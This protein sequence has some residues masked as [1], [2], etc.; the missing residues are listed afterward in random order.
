MQE[1]TQTAAR[2]ACI[3]FL[4]RDKIQVSP[5]LSVFLFLC[6]PGANQI[7]QIALYVLSRG[8][9]EGA[10]RRRTNPQDDGIDLGQAVT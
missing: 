4:L 10:G 9:G 3:S 6:A 1:K 8:V 5:S 7:A 2:S